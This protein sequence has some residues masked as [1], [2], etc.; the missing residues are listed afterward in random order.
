[1][2]ETN[3]Q[4]SLRDLV[5]SSPKGGQLFDVGQLNEAFQYI[6]ST[7]VTEKDEPQPGTIIAN[8]DTVIYD[9]WYDDYEKDIKN[10]DR[11]RYIHDETFY[12]NSQGKISFDNQWLSSPVTIFDKVGKYLISYQAQ[13]NP[14]STPGFEGYRK[15]SIDENQAIVYVHRRPIANFTAKISGNS[16]IYTENSYDLDHIADADKGIVNKL[17]KWRK[18]GEIIWRTGQPTIINDGETIIVRLAVQDREGVWSNPKIVVLTKNSSITNN[19]PVADFILE[20]S[21][22]VKG[23]SNNIY[24]YSYDIDGDLITQ[25][26]WTIYD[27]NNNIIYQSS[28]MPNLSTLNKGNY[29]IQLRVKD[30]SLW[31]EPCVRNLTVVIN[32]KPIANFSLGAIQYT[33]SSIN[34]TDTSYDPDGDPIIEREWRIT[35]LGDGTSKTFKDKLPKTLE[36]AGFTKD[37][38]YKFELRV[39]DDPT[40]RNSILQRLWSDW[41]ATTITVDVDLKLTA[42]TEKIISKDT[43]M[44]TSDYKAGQAVIVKAKTEGYAY[45]V[46]AYLILNTTRPVTNLVPDDV[47]Q[48]PLQYQMTWHTK[49]MQ[50]EGYD[51]NMIIPL[52][53]PLSSTY[54]VRVRAYRKKADGT[55]K[56]VTV[57]LPINVNGVM[58]FKSEIIK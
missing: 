28:V 58:E 26:E 9:L 13:D 7:L 53:T 42:W 3:Q 5:N 49:Y 39:M 21:N 44:K 8:E 48:N 11:F 46:D 17:W 4:I 18:Q 52:N 32:N 16:I 33:N 29:K 41:K 14:E 45:K 27:S 51:A 54:K 20:Y 22:M 34:V 30:A 19:P 35:Y 37:G 55:D 23:G 40:R 43:T 6:E 25:R 36:E 50:G 31:S 1:M 47:L 24:D 12:N 38:Q 56:I 10:A 15:W 57:D 2:T